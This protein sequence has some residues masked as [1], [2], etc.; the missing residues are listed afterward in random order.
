VPDP[1]F[2]EPRLARIYDDLEGRR[3]DLDHYEALVDEFDARTVLDVGC[4]TG[5]LACRLACRGLAVIGVDPAAASL[6]VARSKPASDLVTWLHGDA[7][8]LPDSISATVD[9]AV[10]TGNVAQVFLTDDQWAATLTGVHLA[11]RDGGRLVFETRDPA[12]RA[13]DEWTRERSFEVVA[14]TSG[15]VESWVDLL[16][17]SMPF[18]TFRGVV[19]FLDAGEELT[20]ESTLRFREREEID[21][22]LSAAGFSVDEVRDAPD[23]PGR[24]WVYVASRPPVT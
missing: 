23:R 13:W 8:T 6:D 18:V 17:V 10:M 11:L 15:P 1:I 4:G 20:S 14:T 7:T 9:L 3:D 22:T 2:D 12:R 21:A 19:R 5:E 16:D 24:E